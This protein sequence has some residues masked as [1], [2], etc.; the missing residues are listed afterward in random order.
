MARCTGF[1]YAPQARQVVEL[2][3]QHPAGSH[4]LGVKEVRHDLLLQDGLSY[5]AGS[6]ENESRS[7]ALQ[8]VLQG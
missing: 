5:L 2:H 6:P 1:G 7:K 3:A 4:T 8:K